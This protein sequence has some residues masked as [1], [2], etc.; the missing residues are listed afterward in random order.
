MRIPSVL[1]STSLAI[2]ATIVVAACGAGE[3]GTNPTTTVDAPPVLSVATSFYPVTHI[4]TRIVGDLPVEIVQL[5]P[6]GS[7]AHSH[8][9]TARQIDELSGVDVMFHLGSGLQASI[10]KAIEQLP[11]SVRVV[12]LSTSIEMLPVTKSDD[13]DHDHDH[14]DTD[15][16]VWL[17]PA[18]M[19]TMTR[20][21]A[22]ALAEALPDSA[23]VINTN[24]EAHID[25]LDVLGA[26]IDAA[27][28]TCTS[29][30][31][32]TSHDAF[33]YLAAR[34]NLDTVPI[35]GIN[36]DNEPSAKDLEAIAGTA[37][38]AG[39]TTVFLEEQLPDNLT[40]TVADAIGARVAII[41]AVETMTNA[42]LVSG[43]DY[44]SRMRE[45]IT[46]IATGLGCR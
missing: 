9:L 26:E 3:P 32:V 15:P 18:H 6:P 46:I 1:R 42:E 20:N 5:T 25:E 2:G 22:R 12:D 30:S 40:R 34:A 33:A 16:H 39:A 27:F 11:P 21:A 43:Q 23:P 35:A 37:R 41:S 36:P 4:V 19:A 13:D 24:A 17:D 44:I 28:V 31:L 7:D 45:N 38:G 29:R 14:G 8:E 10:E